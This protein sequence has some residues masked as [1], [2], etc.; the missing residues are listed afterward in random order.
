M[1]AQQPVLGGTAASI[2]TDEWWDRH[3]TR[4]IAAHIARWLEHTRITPNQITSMA[5]AFGVACAFLVGTG[6]LSVMI[7]AGVFLF[8]NTVL[9]CADGQLARL[10]GGGSFMGRLWDGFSDW[11][12]CLAIHFGLIG[13]MSTHS[14]ELF[15]R[16]LSGGTLFVIGMAAILSMCLHCM[17]Y[18][19][20]KN[21]LKGL[22]GYSDETDTPESVTVRIDAANNR[23]ERFFLQLYRAYCRLQSPST[24]RPSASLPSLAQLR[25]TEVRF[26]RWQP[27]GPGM[28]LVAFTV[29]ILIASVAPWAMLLY[30][31]YN[32]VFGNILM[33]WLLK[34]DRQAEV[35]D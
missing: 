4:P 21:N 35:L 7:W 27:I 2:N 5:C 24:P 3:V 16:Q 34:S 15:G 32:L 23:G 25:T 19:L 1:T 9:D 11:I 26:K 31:G 14:V 8:V 6:R 17:Y 12:V 22:A 33:V 29:T 10:R 30:L 18:D 28:H 20:K 13:F